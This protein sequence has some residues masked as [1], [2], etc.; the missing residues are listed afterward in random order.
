MSAGTGEARFA[1]ARLVAADGEPRSRFLAGEPFG[2]EVTLDG[3]GRGA[4]AAP[5]G[6]RRI[7]PARRRGDRRHAFAR[8]ERRGDGLSLRLD[9]PRRRSSSVGSTSAS[10]SS[11]T[12]AAFSTA[13]RA[14]SRSSS[15]RTARAAGS[16]DSKEP[17]STRRMQAHE[18]QDLPGLA[19]A[20]GACAGPPVQ[21]HDRPRGSVAVRDRRQDPEGVSLDEVE[22]CC[23]V[24]HRRRQRRSYT[25][26]S[27][28]PSRARTGSR[29]RSGR[30][31]G[32][33]PTQ[34]SPRRSLTRDRPSF[35]RTYARRVVAIIPFRAGG[36]KSRLP[37]EIRTEVALAMLGDVVEAAAVVGDVRVVTEDAAGRLVATELGAGALDDPGG[38]RAPQSRRGSPASRDLP[39]RERRP[40][41]HA[42]VGSQRARGPPRLGQVAVVEA[43]TGRRT[44]SGCRWPRCSSRS[45]APAARVSSARTPS[46]STFR[47]KTSRSNLVEDVDTLADL[48]RVGVRAGQRTRAIM[49]AIAR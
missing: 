4:V 34:V 43:W 18:L 7:G 16:S 36:S 46:P 1:I 33:A 32:R 6:S 11:G 24:D 25:P 45:T 26:M 28:R 49:E 13:C 3:V 20:D 17:G 12:T 31:Q 19:R 8:L 39:R 5:R 27:S 14:R 48:E 47:S 38:A 22:I 40:A 21:A 29:F 9:V 2:L 44:R 41:A 37:S 30:P 35:A 15:T 23:D 10:R 42:P